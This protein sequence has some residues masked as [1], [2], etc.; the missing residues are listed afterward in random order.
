MPYSGKQHLM[1]QKVVFIVGPTAVGKTDAAA[2]LAAKLRGEII[3]CDSMQVYKGM[4]IISSQ[5]GSVLRK[6]APHHLLAVVSPEKEYNV[7]EYRAAALKMVKEILGRDNLPIF[8]GGTGLYM[9]VLIDGIFKEKTEDQDIRDRLYAEAQKFG[10]MVLHE[11]LVKVDHDAAL[12]IHPNDTKRLIRALE[13]FEA[14]GKP[15]SLLQ[16]ARSGLWGKYDVRIFCLN[17][18]REKLYQRIDERVERMFKEG[19][20]DEVR[21]LLRLRLSKTAACAIGIK[22]LK[23]Y[24]AG[25]CSLDEA[26]ALM[27]KNSRNYAKRQLTW[28]RKDKRIRW[29]EVADDESPSHV[30]ARILKELKSNRHSEAKA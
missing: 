17:M 6:K 7:S 9:T 22:E 2:C 3:S 11:R 28:F 20:M 29:V 23:C 21:S 27:Q 19:I 26:R 5:A 25:L 13:V 18:V 30:A 24:F 16:K 14:T 12:K 15:I 1:K 4:D 10:G 8:V